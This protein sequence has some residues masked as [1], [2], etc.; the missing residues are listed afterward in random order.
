MGEHISK[1]FQPGKINVNV[2]PSTAATASAGVFNRSVWLIVPVER[3]KRVAI[4]CP[5]TFM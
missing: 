4:Y 1:P 3:I 2:H 5:V